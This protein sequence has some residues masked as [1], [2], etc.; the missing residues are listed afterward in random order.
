MLRI[1]YIIALTLSCG[2]ENYSQLQH[3]W[4]HLH[5]NAEP[6]MTSQCKSRNLKDGSEKSKVLNKANNYLR[7]MMHHVI[8]QTNQNLSDSG[9]PEI[10]KGKFGEGRF[11]I[12]AQ[13]SSKINAYANPMTGNIYA[14]LSILKLAENDSQVATFLTHEIAHILLAHSSDYIS[15]KRRISDLPGFD[16]QRLNDVVKS[17]KPAV[18]YTNLPL[19]MVRA[20][21]RR[22]AE[23]EK[24]ENQISYY[25][26]MYGGEIPAIIRCNA[27]GKLQTLLDDVVLEGNKLVL[28]KPK[29]LRWGWAD[30]KKRFYKVRNNTELQDAFKDAASI[31]SIIETDLGASIDGYFNW[32]EKEADEVGMEIMYRSGFNITEVSKFWYRMMDAKGRESERCRKEILAGKSQP[33]GKGSHP[34]TCYRIQDLSVKEIEKHSKNYRIKNDELIDVFPGELKELKKSISKIL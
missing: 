29:S 21:F 33:R 17:C 4:S 30:F 10:F 26:Y 28:G 25:R 14:E 27:A 20:V 13:D 7:K 18:G 34:H 5:R 22:T 3:D 8:T 31:V 11:C 19:S 6:S 16:P 24:I 12:D 32:K 2:V 23:V 1:F 9:L 15:P